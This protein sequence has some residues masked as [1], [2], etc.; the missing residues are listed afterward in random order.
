MAEGLEDV[1]LESV[2]PVVVLLRHLEA[3]QQA[4]RP[5]VYHALVVDVLSFGVG[6]AHLYLHEVVALFAAGIGQAEQAAGDLAA[7][8]EHV[9]LTHADEADIVDLGDSYGVVAEHHVTNLH[10]N[11]TSS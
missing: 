3:V 2:A 9:Q 10:G 6:L 7:D 8:D 4:G 5:E 1:L 11:L